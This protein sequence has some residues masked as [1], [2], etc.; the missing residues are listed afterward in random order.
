M[1]G[2]AILCIRTVQYCI[3]QGWPNKHP[4]KGMQQDI[5]NA[6]NIFRKEMDRDMT[7]K[8]MEYKG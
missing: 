7:I 3:E 5:D 4:G 8:D 1:T 6:I 2:T